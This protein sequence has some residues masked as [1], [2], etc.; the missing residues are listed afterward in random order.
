MQYMGLVSPTRGNPEEEG[1]DSRLLQRRKGSNDFSASRSII[2]KLVG[3]TT[4]GPGTNTIMN[5]SLNSSGMRLHA[6]PFENSMDYRAPDMGTHAV[7]SFDRHVIRETREEN[8]KQ[9]TPGQ[10]NTVPLGQ[11]DQFRMRVYTK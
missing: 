5:K 7:D 10:D 1:D 6:N 2:E 11:R 4:G 9:G 8:H 3:N